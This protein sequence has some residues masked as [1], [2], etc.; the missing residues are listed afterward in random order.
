MWQ[1][2]TLNKPKFYRFGGKQLI[3]LTRYNV[4]VSR[5]EL[6]LLNMKLHPSA[7]QNIHH[8]KLYISI[9]FNLYLTYI[10]FSFFLKK[11]FS[12]L[13]ANEY[14]PYSCMHKF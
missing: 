4:Y 10:F 8:K 7:Q 11:I 5:A 6:T 14:E 12:I 3:T 1:Q 13:I 2:A 9:I